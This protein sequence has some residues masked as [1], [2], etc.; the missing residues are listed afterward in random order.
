MKR[1]N[2]RVRRNVP[3]FRDAGDG[4]QIDG[5]F[6]DETFEQR[7]DDVMF[8]DAGDDMGV[9]VLRFGAV[10]EVKDLLTISRLDTRLAFAAAGKDDEQER[11]EQQAAWIH[12]C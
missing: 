7:E 9:E 1:V 4:M 2:P 11:A 8:G 12:S 3:A 10:A 6:G 5:I